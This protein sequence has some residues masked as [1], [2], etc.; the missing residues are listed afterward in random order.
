MSLVYKGPP[1]LSTELT[2]VEGAILRSNSQNK[3]QPKLTCNFM[4]KNLKKKK[5][6]YFNVILTGN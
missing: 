6:T 3:S 2:W 4:A 5:K 1:E